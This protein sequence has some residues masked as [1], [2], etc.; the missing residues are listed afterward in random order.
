MNPQE[1]LDKVVLNLLTQN[2]RAE[3]PNGCMYRAPSG[4]KCAI[5]G[6]IL[7]K[8]YSSDLEHKYPEEAEVAE[9]LAK[10][11]KVERAFTVQELI[12][13][14]NLQKIHDGYPIEEMA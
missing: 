12:F 13:L 7:D 6:L 10:S 8:H 14:R 4:L 1:V 3:G 2:A 5:G 11:L 9:A